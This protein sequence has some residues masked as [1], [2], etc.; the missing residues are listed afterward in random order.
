MSIIEVTPDRLRYEA[1]RLKQLKNSQ[2]SE[3][4]KLRVLIK[5]LSDCWQGEAQKA[6]AEKFNSMA[7]IFGGFSSLLTAYA[8]LMNSSA[9]KL[10]QTDKN[11][12]N[13]ISNI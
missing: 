3:M 2:E 4:D 7:Y 1:E 8:D 13:K 10:Q 5:S 11:M 9:N 12:R 6:F